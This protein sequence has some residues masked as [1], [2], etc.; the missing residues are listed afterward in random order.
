MTVNL[1]KHNDHT[2]VD[3]YCLRSHRLLAAA[4]R[5]R[6]ARRRKREEKRKGS[7]RE[8]KRKGRDKM[9]EEV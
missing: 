4:K 6:K 5:E 9:G 2:H 7:K 1:H 8:G 3:A